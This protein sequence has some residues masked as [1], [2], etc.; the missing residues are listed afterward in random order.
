MLVLD[1]ELHGSSTE[2]VLVAV[3][4]ELV[5]V[6]FLMKSQ[7]QLT[8]VVAAAAPPQAPSAAAAAAAAVAVAHCPWP[9]A[10]LSWQMVRPS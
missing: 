7:Q 10:L 5:A 2:S 4:P 9:Q 3:S 8:L 1:E 6:E